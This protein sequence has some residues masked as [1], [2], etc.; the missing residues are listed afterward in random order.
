MYSVSAAGRQTDAGMEYRTIPEAQSL[1]VFLPAGGISSL[2]YLP[3]SLRRTGYINSKSTSIRSAGFT[4]ILSS[5]PGGIP[6][7]AYAMFHAATMKD[8]LWGLIAYCALL[9]GVVRLV[10]YDAI[11]KAKPTSGW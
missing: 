9:L 10:Q 5:F 1:S 11:E 2:A 3:Q 4:G 8:A 6:V 7:V